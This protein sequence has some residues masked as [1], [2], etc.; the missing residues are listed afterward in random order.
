MKPLRSLQWNAK[1]ICPY[2]DGSHGGWEWKAARWS[3]PRLDFEGQPSMP[4]YT[5]P[6]YSCLLKRESRGRAVLY[7]SVLCRRSR[8]IDSWPSVLQLDS[9]KLRLILHQ[10]Y[11]YTPSFTVFSGYSSNKISLNQCKLILDKV[12]VGRFEKFSFSDLQIMAQR[13]LT[14]R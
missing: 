3:N 13:K 11:N 12:Q 1:Q 2:G 9:I 14:S 10:T 8:N 7:Y 5:S 6:V 4:W